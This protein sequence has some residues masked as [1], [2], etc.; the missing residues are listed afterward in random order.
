MYAELYLQLRDPRMIAPMRVQ[1]DVMLAEPRTGSLKWLVPDILHRWSWCDSLFMGPG[2]WARLTAVTGDQRY[3]ENA[4][5]NWWITSDYL[6]DKEE[7]LYYRDSRYFDQKE[8]SGKKVFWSRGNGW[9]PGGLARMLQYIPEQHPARGRFLQ[10]YRAI[11]LCAGLGS[12][13]W[14]SATR[15]IRSCRQARLAGLEQPCAGQRQVDP[16]S[17]DRRRSEEV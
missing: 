4:I 9:V 15:S 1:F 8:A 6:Y 12:A 13:P 5:K 17:A 2:A 10:Q 16:C 7:H 3:L 11:Y 14:R